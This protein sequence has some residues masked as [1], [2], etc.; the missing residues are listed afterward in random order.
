MSQL[1]VYTVRP[2]VPLLFARPI[3]FA[4]P[5]DETKPE[6]LMLRCFLSP[7][8]IVTLTAAVRDLHLSFPGRFLT[9]V[10]TPCPAFWENSPYITHLDPEDPEVVI[11]PCEYPLI[12]SSNQLPYHF[13][14]GY[15]MFLSDMLGVHTRPFAFKGD[16]HVS[17]LEKSWLSQ[18]GEITGDPE[19]RFWIIVSG[20]KKDF[21][22]K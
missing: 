6:K 17:D 18:V 22:A 3:T 19:S 16:I 21:T 4:H 1:A 7:G 2:L 9:D 20:G 8:D 10:Q 13:I 11:V 15:R 12:H 5:E 14:H